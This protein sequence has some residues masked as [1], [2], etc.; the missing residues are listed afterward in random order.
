MF[1]N[2]PSIE[3]TL[4]WNYVKFKFEILDVFCHTRAFNAALFQIWI[5]VL[6][7]LKVGHKFYPS[8]FGSGH[9]LGQPKMERW[10]FNKGRR[11]YPIEA[12]LF[13][14]NCT[15]LGPPKPGLVT[16]LL[17]EN[18]EYCKWWNIYARMCTPFGRQSCLSLQWS[19]CMPML[20]G[21]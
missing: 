4:F 15:Y 9:L 10:T 8:I 19:I 2:Y 14:F 5:H 7:V 6:H 21:I 3:G 1:Q 13:S 16:H 18:V 17:V 20:A 12:N 11:E